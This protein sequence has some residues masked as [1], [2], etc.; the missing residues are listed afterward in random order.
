[1]VVVFYR[2]EKTLAT[3]LMFATLQVFV[4]ST[5]L[6]LFLLYFSIVGEGRVNQN[7]QLT[8]MHTLLVRAHNKIVDSLVAAHSEWDDET[9]F[10]EARRILIA[11][12]LHITYKEFLPHIIPENLIETRNLKPKISGYNLY[13]PKLPNAGLV[14][15]TNPVFRIFHSSLQGV[16]LLYN[17]GLDPTISI[18]LTDY[19]NSPQI[20]EED[21]RFDELILGLITQPMQSIDEYYTAQI[22]Q[23]LFALGKPY[24]TDL[25]SLDIQRSRDFGT[26]AYPTLLYACTGV[27]VT[28]FDDLKDLWPADVIALFE[29]M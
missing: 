12:Y 28:S 10:Q 21:G 18:N 11:F 29:I 9:L 24:G 4:S 7:P 2:Q 13:D 27:K 16:M 6:V 20:I 8:I 14:S 1:M 5:I 23:K 15:F 26:P 22:S 25:N 19:M 17:Y 3:S